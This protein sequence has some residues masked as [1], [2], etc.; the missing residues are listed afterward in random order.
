[1]S[2]QLLFSSVQILAALVLGVSIAG[3]A[4]GPSMTVDEVTSA[5]EPIAALQKNL[6]QV[7]AAG[8]GV[9]APS[10]YASASKKLDE[11]IA[12]TRAGNAQEGNAIAA[13]ATEDLAK[14]RENIEQSSDVFREALAARERAKDA[15][16]SHIY[17]DRTEELESSLRDAA[18]LVERNDLEGAKRRRQAL[19]DGYS[20]LE[21]AAL[22]D[23]VVEAAKATIKSAEK[24]EAKKYAPK[25]FEAAREEM[26]LARAILDADRTDT[27]KANEHAQRAMYLA[28]QSAGITELIK[29]MNRREFDREQVVRW[30]QD[31]LST[32][33]EPV[34]ERLRFD[35]KHRE[36]MRQMR[37]AYVTLIAQ[38]DEVAAEGAAGQIQL[39]LTEEELL[40][41]KRK[42]EE[43]RRRFEAAQSMFTDTEA[44]VYRKLENV[45]I[46]A[47]GFDFPTGESEIRTENFVLLN[48]ITQVIALFPGSTVE[49]SGHTDS[50]GSAALNLDLSGKRAANVAK[51]LNEVGG[52]DKDRLSS[53]G[54]GSE[55]PVA[56]NDTAAGRASNRRVEILIVNP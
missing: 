34:G 44:T 41:K 22:K 6:R 55:R 56:M 9:L 1:M 54:F 32:V 21:L 5:Y 4:S 11:A 10:G 14:I 25:T 53:E 43:E 2:R 26:K 27:E 49:I 39:A 3:C 15:G 18:A 51:F 48:K 16:A 31:Q 7:D 45:L 30:Y 47:H 17:P 23:G 13:T 8:A 46:D 29:D 36:A 28:R 33:Y 50:T 12:V 35:Q 42:D 52:I 24:Q 37:E 19:V 40:E 38:R 20:N